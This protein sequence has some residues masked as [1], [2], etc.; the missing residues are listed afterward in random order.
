MKNQGQ[1][2]GKLTKN[3]WNNFK[4]IQKPWK[5]TGHVK[6]KL[7]G[8]T[9]KYKNVWRGRGCKSLRENPNPPGFSKTKG[10]LMGK[11]KNMHTNG[12]IKGN[13]RG[14]SRTSNGKTLKKHTQT[15]GTYRAF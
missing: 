11:S 6:G 1:L 7:K 15:L 4:N 12:K 10:K 8:K 9:Q 5:H 13:S 2:K 3:P 14:N